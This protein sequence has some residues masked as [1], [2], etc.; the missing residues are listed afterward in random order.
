[1]RNPPFPSGSLHALC[2]VGGAR[3]SWN[4]GA[5]RKPVQKQGKRSQGFG[6]VRNPPFPSGSL[7]APY[8]L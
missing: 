6:S 1:M 8:S 4:N 3:K 5:F 2:R 7:H